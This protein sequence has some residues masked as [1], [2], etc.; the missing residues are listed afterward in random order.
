[1][2]ESLRSKTIGALSWS[3]LEAIGLRGV[4]FVFGIILARLL[5]PE[6]FGLIGMLTIFIA[7]GQAFLD[8]GFGA[9]LVQ[10]RDATPTD[11]CSIFYFNIAAGA[12]VASLLFLTAPWIAGFY[13]QPV[14]VPLIRVLSLT[15]VI[16][17]FGLI[18]SITLTRDINFKTQ[19]VTS[20]IGSLL[21]GVIGITM[22]ATGFGVWSLATQQ[23]SN[24]FFRTVFL[25]LLN[26]WRPGL[27]FRCESL[28]EMF[29]F[30]SRL[31]VSGLLNQIFDN[32]YLLVI[33]KLFSATDLGLFTRAKS[34]ADIPSQTLSG[35][36]AQVTFPVFSTI[37]DDPARLKRGMKKALTVLVMVNFP[38]MIGLS[39]AARPLV[40][41]LLTE[42]WAES[43]P[44]LQAFCF[45]GLLFPVHAINLNV[46]QALGRSDLF[47]RLEILKKVLI[48]ANIVITWHWGI[49][50]MID[51]MIIT[52]I[53]SYYLNSYYT[54]T[55][56][57]YRF[58]EQL[59]DLL[60][61]LI[62]AGL[63]G[64][65]VCAAGLFA[66]SNDWSMLLAQLSVG[67]VLY[68]CVCR[69]FRLAAFMETWQAGWNKILFV[70]AKPAR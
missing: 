18:H 13:E 68:I 37:Q 9:A 52:S 36:V 50:A 33:G 69:L 2:A 32:I 23:I 54:G 26:P 67:I 15:V 43:V 11:V 46:L 62:V 35:M 63:M 14:L 25:W 30:G 39:A 55:L 48:V 24:T 29:G 66:F 56:I 59:R 41:V 16:N 38:I 10:K 27:T 47:L 58:W 5:F 12:A 21:S 17:S 20:I 65:A 7:V 34:L 40:L 1:M 60:S 64:I 6:Q 57:G 49:S 28:R 53:L 19:A 22:A 3:F 51:G 42:R 61:Y 4:Q 70:M 31:M 45:L 8:S 44:Y